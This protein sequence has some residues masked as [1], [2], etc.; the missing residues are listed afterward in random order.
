MTECGPTEGEN[1]IFMFL[2]SGLQPPLQ[3]RFCESRRVKVG[4]DLCNSSPKT[5]MRDRKLI[6]QS[7][8][9]VFR[10]RRSW[11]RGGGLALWIKLVVGD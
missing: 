6:V 7:A 2:D 5:R 8:L 9:N 11:K 1:I 10:A 4:E 3:C